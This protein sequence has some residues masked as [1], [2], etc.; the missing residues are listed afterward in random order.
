MLGR[1]NALAAHP[2]FYNTLTNNC[3]N[4]IARHV[5]A[6][7]PHRLPWWSWRFVLPAYSDQL[8]YDAGLLDTTLPLA[9][10][11]RHF[12]INA[13]AL[14]YAASPDFSQRIRMPE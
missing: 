2:E 9:E 6:I 1:A 5:N 7:A 10:A 14:K 3:T 12:Q 13:R 4:S 8:A 11:R